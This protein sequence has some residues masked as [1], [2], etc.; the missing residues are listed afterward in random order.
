MRAQDLVV[1]RVPDGLKRPHRQVDESRKGLAVSERNLGGVVAVEQ[2]RA[3]HAR[4]KRQTVGQVG[5]HVLL[6]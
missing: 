2:G 5:A 6:G 1:A 4:K 3:I